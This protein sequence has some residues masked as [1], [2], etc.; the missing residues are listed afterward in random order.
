MNLGEAVRV[1][2]EFTKEIQDVCARTM[3]AGSIR[4][5]KLEPNDIEI[6]AEPLFTKSEERPTLFG[7]ESLEVNLLR[8]RMDELRLRGHVF[9]DRPSKDGKK[10]PFGPR[11]YRV[12][13]NHLGRLYPVDLFTVFPP[14]DWYPQ[15]VIRT[16]SAEFSHFLVTEA[17]KYNLRFKD[18]HIERQ[19]EPP[20][21]I[22]PPSEEYVFKLC[23]IEYLEPEDRGEDFMKHIVYVKKN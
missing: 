16:G 10:S 18:G 20:T 3:V 5:K 14:A 15:V 17:W 23:G 19:G 1:A 8:R 13:F 9:A 22:V 4:R 21:I 2:A 7:Q 6:L 12:S 11:Y